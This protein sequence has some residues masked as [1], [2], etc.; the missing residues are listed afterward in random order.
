MDKWL[1]DSP[2]VRLPSSKGTIMSNLPLCRNLLFPC[3]CKLGFFSPDSLS[4]Y[5]FSCIQTFSIF[6]SWPGCTTGF[7]C[8]LC[9]SVETVLPPKD[10]SCDAFIEMQSHS[11]F[12]WGVKLNKRDWLLAEDHPTFSYNCCTFNSL[13]LRKHFSSLQ[14]LLNIYK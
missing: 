12:L 7:L 9:S 14:I 4:L 3:G 11:I 1:K 13:Y 8:Q 2:R 5:I 6:S 10:S